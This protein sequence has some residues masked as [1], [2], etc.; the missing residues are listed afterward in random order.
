[1]N[2]AKITEATKAQ[3]E[4]TLTKLKICNYPLTEEEVSNLYNSEL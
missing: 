1:M 3:I 2:V 4:N